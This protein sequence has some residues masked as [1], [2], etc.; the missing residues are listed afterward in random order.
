MSLKLLTDITIQKLP[1]PAMG[2][3]VY[4]EPTGLG[5]RVSQGGAEPFVVQ[6]G[7]E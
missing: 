2:Q 4:Y 6:T 7:S 1:I 5:L 3:R